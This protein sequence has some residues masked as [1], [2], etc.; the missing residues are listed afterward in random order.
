MVTII[1]NYIGK[2]LGLGYKKSFLSLTESTY[3]IGQ[4]QIYRIIIF[5][6]G[7]I[8]I[9]LKLLSLFLQEHYRNNLLTSNRQDRRCP[10]QIEQ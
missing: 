7:E 3:D 6:E 8:D 4:L 5:E 2:T 10:V 9:M 1:N